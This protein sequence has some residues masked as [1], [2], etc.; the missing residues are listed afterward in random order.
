MLR[1]DPIMT[2]RIEE[3]IDELRE[4]FTIAIVT[5]DAASGPGLAE[6]SVFPYG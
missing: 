3:L 1:I 6:D 5:T 2:A 4:K